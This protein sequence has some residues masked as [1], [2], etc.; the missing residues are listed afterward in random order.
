M[1]TKPW[2]IE[3]SPYSPTRLAMF[4]RFTA[5]MK[6]GCSTATTQPITG[7]RQHARA[8]NRAESA[9]APTRLHVPGTA[10]YGDAYVA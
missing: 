4:S 3:N 9:L 2:P 5:E 8:G 6:R 1:I 7:H 10:A